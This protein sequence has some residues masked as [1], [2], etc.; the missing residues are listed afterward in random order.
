M[1]IYPL[2][3]SGFFLAL[4]HHYLLFDDYQGEL[5]RLDPEIPLY[6]FVSHSHAD[7]Y[8]RDIVAVTS[9]YRHR[10]FLGSGIPD[11]VFLPV[12]PGDVLTPDD[13]TVTALPS[14]DEGVAFLVEVEGK[15]IFHAG[16]LHL[17]YW[18]DDTA[19]ERRDMERRYHAALEPLR[20][21]AI[22]AAFLVLDSRQTEADALGG[23]AYFNDLTRTKAIFPMHA[24]DDTATMETRIPKLPRCDNIFFPWR[25]RVY[26]L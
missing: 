15:T 24:G 8:R 25:H 11:P 6:V 7:H 3:H 17:W 5:P 10:T 4:P 2:Y 26:E 20:G 16:D 14:T 1:E 23:I 22:D 18:D 9:Y 12:A 21:R 19:E 13:L